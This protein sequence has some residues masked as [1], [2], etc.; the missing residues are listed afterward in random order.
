MRIH[1]E[2]ELTEEISLVWDGSN[3]AVKVY[4]PELGRFI[5][6]E[7]SLAQLKSFVRVTEKS[8]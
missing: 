5:E 6:S 8:W 2:Q 4:Y 1:I 7:V 3:L